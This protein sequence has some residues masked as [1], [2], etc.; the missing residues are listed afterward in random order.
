MKK[1]AGFGQKFIKNLTG[2]PIVFLLLIAAIVLYVFGSGTIRGFAQTLGLGIVLS[3]I[4]ALLVTR[5]LL[6]QLQ[7]LLPYSRWLY[8]MERLPWERQGEVRKE[9]AR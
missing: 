1:E 8:I 5:L 6:V 4:S 7:E 2:N 3:M 9:V